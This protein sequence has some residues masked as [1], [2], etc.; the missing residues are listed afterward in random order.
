MHL[1]LKTSNKQGLAFFEVV[2]IAFYFLVEINVELFVHRP[3]F[4]A[5][6]VMVFFS[7]GLSRGIVIKNTKYR[8]WV[9][10]WALITAV[11]LIY[12]IRPSYT[13]TAL[14]TI[15][16]RGFVLFLLICRIET[17]EQLVYL[18][19]IYIAVTSINLV[20]IL[21]KVDVMSLG[22]E[23]IGVRTIESDVSWN[24]N[25][26]GMVL[27]LAVSSIF[28]LQR[29]KQFVGFHRVISFAL[30][31]VFIFITLLTGSRIALIMML[32]IPLSIYF[33]SS[34]LR[35]I[36]YK[37]I[38]ILISL[39]LA[40]YLIMNVPQIYDVLGSRIERLILSLQGKNVIDGSISS[41]RELIKD[42]IEWFRSKPLLGYGMYT[43]MVLSKQFFAYEWYAHNNYIEILV[44]T[45][46]LGL[47]GYYWYYIY[48]LC[49]SISQKLQSRKIIVSLIIVSL[50]CDFAVVS[51]KDFVF[52][53][54]IALATIVMNLD[55]MNKDKEEVIV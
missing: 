27:A 5:A 19:K 12:S 10:V 54:L 11:S 18:L 28:V 41:R 55:M 32:L 31:L 6:V 17:K 42:G 49:Y 48:M 30:V 21:S 3:V 20:Y 37:V 45:G 29:K 13:F 22:V 8:T 25:S 34:T 40:Y 9:I 14:L 36:W 26:I 44:G 35:N 39:Y 1:V 15:L 16:A 38:I 7:F 43:F 2:S 4:I 47:V 50:I 51:F 53:F 24:S 33:L 46:I 52:Q 23:R